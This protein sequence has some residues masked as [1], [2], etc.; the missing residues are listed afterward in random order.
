MEEV[1]RDFPDLEKFQQ[2]STEDKVRLFTSLS[3]PAQKL[4]IACSAFASSVS[5]EMARPVARLSPE[6]FEEA[7]TSLLSTPYFS[8][9][10]NGRLLMADKMKEFIKTDLKRVWEEQKREGI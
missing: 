6:D 4:L 3:I 7:K 5:P 10:P 2:M 1:K 8:I 9:I